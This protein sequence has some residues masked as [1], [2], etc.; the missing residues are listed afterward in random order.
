MGYPVPKQGTAHY[1][2]RDHPGR[3]AGTNIEPAMS[4]SYLYVPGAT[5]WRK[6]NPAHCNPHKV[7]V[8]RGW[9]A[10]AEQRRTH[11]ITGANFK[12]IQWWIKETFVGT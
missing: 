10:A 9:E 1:F 5:R 7:Y 4:M 12:R 6:H 11:P 3:E 2:L 8:P